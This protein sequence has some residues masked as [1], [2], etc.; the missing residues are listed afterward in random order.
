MVQVYLRDTPSTVS[1]IKGEGATYCLRE[2]G[3]MVG[4]YSLFSEI[5][6]KKIDYYEYVLNS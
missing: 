6:M 1:L 4:E 2:V 3:L 5:E